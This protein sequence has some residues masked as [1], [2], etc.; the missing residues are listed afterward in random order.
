MR[1]AGEQSVQQVCAALVGLEEIPPVLRC[2]FGVR[3][4][5]FCGSRHWL[6]LGFGRH[7]RKYVNGPW[8]GIWGRVGMRC[9]RRIFKMEDQRRHYFNMSDGLR[10]QKIMNRHPALC[11]GQGSCVVR[12][13]ADLTR[14]GLLA[15]GCTRQAGVDTATTAWQSRRKLLG[16]YYFRQRNW[17]ISSR[18]TKEQI[19]IIL[20]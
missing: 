11:C 9:S 14:S 20:H 4:S 3:L 6:S 19:I 5:W 15:L 1:Q 16:I 17:C 2:F 13:S 10:R 18:A 8:W 12:L 7:G